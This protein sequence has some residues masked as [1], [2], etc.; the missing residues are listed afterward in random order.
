M[1]RILDRHLNFFL[2]RII[3]ILLEPREPG[4]RDV[5]TNCRGCC[6]LLSIVGRTDNVN[7][8]ALAYSTWGIGDITLHFCQ[9]VATSR[10]AA[11]DTT[12]DCRTEDAGVNHILAS[13]A[14]CVILLLSTYHQRLSRLDAKIHNTMTLHWHP[15][16]GGAIAFADVAIFIWKFEVVRTRT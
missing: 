8:E 6:L 1:T 5:G 3:L 14:V 9:L 2:N 12:A 4:F 16:R 10:D 7:Y 15:V 11:D 13:R